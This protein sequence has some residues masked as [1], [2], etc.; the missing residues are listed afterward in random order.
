MKKISLL[1]MMLVCLAFIGFSQAT[2]DNFED[3][4]VGDYNFV[5]GTFIPYNANPDKTGNTSPIAASYKRNPAEA[6]DVLVIDAPGNMED[7]TDYV[8]GTKQMTIDVWSPNVGTVVQISLEDSALAKPA[9]FPTGRHSAYLA[10]TTVANAWETLT[11]TFDNQPDASVSSTGV[12]RMVL[13]F[14]PNTN[15]DDQYYFD[16]LVG[17]GLATDPCETATIADS[18]LNDFECNQNSNMSFSHGILRR[19]INPDQSGGNTSGVVGRYTRNAGE[20]FDVIT[21]SF[22]TP[23]MLGDTNAFRLMVW[24]PGAPTV[25][26]LSLQTDNGSGPVDV[27]AVSDSTSG[28][29]QWE[30]L[31]FRF[32]NLASANINAFVLLFDPGDFTSDTYYFDNFSYVTDA[33]LVSI[34]NYLSEGAL[35]VFPNPSQGKTQFSYELTN[36]GNVSLTIYDLAGRQVDAITEGMQS[37]G[38]HQITWEARDLPDGMYVYQ[39]KVNNEV[40]SGK[41]II[42]R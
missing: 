8:S 25:V 3:S 33:D 37:M 26:R 36:S 23:P 40:S 24:D 14:A 41:I 4:R 7:L 10:T 30:E 20:E 42:S 31:E 9:N 21:G 15:T 16:N 5:S 17:P 11:F 38:N 1:T 32:G 2:W 18:I 27:V 12:G 39:F 13:L 28:S 29:S 19:V 34:D 22:P 35:N 6:F